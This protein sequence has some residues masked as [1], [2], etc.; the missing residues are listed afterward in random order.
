MN[1]ST[2]QEIASKEGV[3]ESTISRKLSKP[4]VKAY[5]EELQARLVS[6][7]LSKA[8]DNIHEVVEGYKTAPDESKRCEH[9]FKASLRLM[10]STGLLTSNQQSIYIQQI[11][12]D[13]RTEM[14]E[15]V[16]ELFNRV[17]AA[18]QTNLLDDAIDI[19]PE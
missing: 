13:N 9:G 16:K 12:N 4:E 6:K 11:Y 8:V 17:T 15:I 5:L 19:I 2:L 1:G 14:P 7:T 10:E 3:H 18:P